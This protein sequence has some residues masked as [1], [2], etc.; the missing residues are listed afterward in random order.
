MTDDD[1]SLVAFFVAPIVPAV[2]FAIFI[3]G[4]GGGLRADLFSLAILSGIGYFCSFFTVGLLGLPAFLILRRC[5]CNGLAASTISGALL[6]SLVGFIL[7]P[8]ASYWTLSDWLWEI[9]GLVLMGGVTG[10]TFWASRMLCL[11]V[12]CFKS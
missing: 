4:F 6:G 5:D 7:V 10:L 1:A 9:R 11:R 12:G 2:A 8:R 3:P